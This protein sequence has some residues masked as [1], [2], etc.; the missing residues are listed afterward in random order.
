MQL[1]LHDF[2]WWSRDF[3]LTWQTSFPIKDRS[4]PF[5]FLLTLVQVLHLLYPNNHST[6][7][8]DLNLVYRA[9]LQK[10]RSVPT[11][12]SEKAR[13]SEL[14]VE[15]LKEH[16]G[17]NNVGPK[18]KRMP[19]KK[20]MQILQRHWFCTHTHTKINMKL[21]T[22]KV[23]FRWSSVSLRDAFQRFQPLIFRGQFSEIR[24]I[25][26]GSRRMTK[27]KTETR[28]F[29]IKVNLLYVRNGTW[30]TRKWEPA[31][32]GV[33]I[34]FGRLFVRIPSSFSIR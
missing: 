21:P 29:K 1:M 16:F 15:E 6:W 22:W 7:P 11:T 18:E 27:S 17:C 24:F 13:V 30:F 32:S 25:D 19:P 33:Y 28:C 20:N 34:L 14:Q 10:K 2:R 5:W 31:E 8:G 23:W 4:T 26:H 12:A 3:H 9:K